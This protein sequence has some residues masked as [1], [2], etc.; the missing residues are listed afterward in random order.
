MERPSLEA[1]WATVSHVRNT[2]GVGSVIA[3][4]IPRSVPIKKARLAR[5]TCTSGLLSGLLPTDSGRCLPNHDHY[6][7]LDVEV[8]STLGVRRGVCPTFDAGWRS[9]QGSETVE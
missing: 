8:S 7:P 2:V 3:T 5:N 9:R 1:A 4:S 6:S